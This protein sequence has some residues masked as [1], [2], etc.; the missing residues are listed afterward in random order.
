MLTVPVP[1]KP[2]G[3]SPIRARGTAHQRQEDHEAARAV[4]IER[5]VDPQD[6]HSTTPNA[7]NEIVASSQITRYRRR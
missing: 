6:S 7:R 5:Q 3:A 4:D 2:R 1:R